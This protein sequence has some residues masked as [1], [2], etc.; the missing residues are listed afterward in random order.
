MVA[1]NRMDMRYVKRRGSIDSSWYD[2]TATLYASQSQ[3]CRDESGPLRKSICVIQMVVRYKESSSDQRR[4]THH[5]QR[6]TARVLRT[7]ISVLWI[8]QIALDI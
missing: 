3:A 6:D 2:R 5:N 1:A 4:C 8:Q 7:R